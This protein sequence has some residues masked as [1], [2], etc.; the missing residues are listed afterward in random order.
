VPNSETEETATDDGACVIFYRL[1]MHFVNRASP[2][3]FPRMIVAGLY[4]GD[5]TQS[6]IKVGFVNQ[7]Q[8]GRGADHF[9]EKAR[10]ILINMPRY[11]TA[12]V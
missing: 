5:V 12:N 2:R 8:I 7:P 11:P 6:C 1:V 10:L 9:I 3:R 4:S